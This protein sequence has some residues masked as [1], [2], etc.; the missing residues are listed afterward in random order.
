MEDCA[1]VF[2]ATRGL[3]LPVP[4]PLCMDHSHCVTLTFVSALLSPEN[5]IWRMVVQLLHPPTSH[6]SCLSL[7]SFFFHPL[8]H[9]CLCS[10]CPLPL[11][12][13]KTEISHYFT[14]PL[15][16]RA[17]MTDWMTFWGLSLRL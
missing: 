10:S 5:I 13:H 3:P 11:N 17:D 7:G 4:Q 2:P 12:K 16:G 6:F 1:Q 14:L 15:M 8:P 9:I